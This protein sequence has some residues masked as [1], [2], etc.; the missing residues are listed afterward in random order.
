MSRLVKGAFFFSAG[1]AILSG[2]SALALVKA[3]D[4]AAANAAADKRGATF[5]EMGDLMDRKLG[6]A[7]RNPAAFDP[8]AIKATAARMATLAG[9]IP[10]NFSTDTR[11]FRVKTSAKDVVWQ[12]HPDFLA[13]AKALS[14]A[15]ANLQ[16][17]AGVSTDR[18]VIGTAIMQ[19]GQSCKSCHET[20]K[21]PD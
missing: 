10:A 20:Y 11:G 12:T 6:P 19:V 21:V 3:T 8:A 18:K 13:K 17:V 15:L 7:M 4:Q 14:G 2:G 5:E 16:K 1:L 9:Q